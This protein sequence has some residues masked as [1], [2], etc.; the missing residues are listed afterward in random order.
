MPLDYIKINTEISTEKF[1][2]DLINAIGALRNAIDQ[3]EKCKA[4][5]DHMNNGI[6]FTDIET[7][8]G[9]PS[10]TGQT[11]YDLLNGTLGAMKGTF[12]NA[13]AVTLMERVG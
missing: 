1:A 3:L 10:G 8:F 13:D 6:V 11:I 7:H 4:L 12:Q 5:M 2:A 9:L